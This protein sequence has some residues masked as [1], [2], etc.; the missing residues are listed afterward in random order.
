MV[1]SNC[2]TKLFMESMV[3]SIALVLIGRSDQ[4]VWN[5]MLYE[6]P[7]R[8]LSF[9]TLTTKYFIS[10]FQVN[11]NAKTTKEEVSPG[12]DWFLFHASWT[13]DGFDKIDKFLLID[14]WYF[15]SQKCPQYFDQELLPDLK[16]RQWYIRDKQQDQEKRLKEHGCVRDSSNGI[17][18]KSPHL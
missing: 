16:I 2:R 14:E 8:M 15:S 11:V 10:G 7:F 9:A 1:R 5:M 13:T 17:Y 3:N 18:Q 12:Y 6:K 4:I